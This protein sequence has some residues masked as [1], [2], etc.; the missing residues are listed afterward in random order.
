MF[1]ENHPEN[2]A[3]KPPRHRPI[4]SL[5]IPSVHSPPKEDDTMISVSFHVW[6]SRLT[7]IRCW[8]VVMCATVP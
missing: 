1:F 5:S 3:A 2:V 6:Y 4:S 7:L 8:V